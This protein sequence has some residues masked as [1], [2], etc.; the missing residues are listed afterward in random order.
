MPLFGPPNVEKLKSN[1]DVN[2]LIKALSDKK[3]E[4]RFSAAEALG[5]MGDIRAVE[6]LIVVLNADSSMYAREI[7]AK[8]LGKLKDARAVDSLITALKK[9]P[10]AGQLQEN[11]A[12]ALGEIKDTRAVEPLIAALFG[13]FPSKR[14]AAV[15][16][17]DEFDDARAIRA[18]HCRAER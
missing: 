12:K 8:A 7:A 16:A 1:R 6:P 13:G 18:A 3:N 4:I 17:L 15:K 9:T 14:Q 10:S 11:A 2:G 5:D